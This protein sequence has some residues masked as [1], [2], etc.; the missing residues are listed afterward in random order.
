MISKKDTGQKKSHLGQNYWY[1]YA[2]YSVFWN[3]AV[4]LTDT[5]HCQDW[6][7][8]TT[9]K[10]DL[11]NLSYCYART[12]QSCHLPGETPGSLVLSSVQIKERDNL[13]RKRTNANLICKAFKFRLK[14]SKQNSTKITE[15]LSQ[16][17]ADFS[18]PL[19]HST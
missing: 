7:H 12:K 9:V 4:R 1:G 15:Y 13:H 2:V 19:I 8:K 16:K 6:S 11:L 10:F 17:L 5:Q 18:L 14:K 3:Y